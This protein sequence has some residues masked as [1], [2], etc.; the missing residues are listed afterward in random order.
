MLRDTLVDPQKNKDVTKG[1]RAKIRRKKTFATKKV[2]VALEAY[3]N[4]L[5]NTFERVVYSAASSDACAKGAL[6]KP[7]NGSNRKGNLKVEA[8]L[9]MNRPKDL[10]K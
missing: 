6:S 7:K 2:V 9:V 8:Q 3:S 4:L 10:Q 5:K 1:A